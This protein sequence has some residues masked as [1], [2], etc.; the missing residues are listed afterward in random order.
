M[1]VEKI[2]EAGDYR[3]R[4][5]MFRANSVEGRRERSPSVDV[6]VIGENLTT[7]PAERLWEKKYENL[8]G[9]CVRNWFLTDEFWPLAH[10]GQDNAAF[11]VASSVEAVDLK[12]GQPL[13]QLRTGDT[14]V[15]AIRT[16]PAHQH[17]LVLRKALTYGS[18]A[19][20][21]SPEGNV[22]WVA[23]QIL[24]SLSGQDHFRSADP[25][26]QLLGSNTL[27]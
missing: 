8:P 14:W 6:T 23:R 12:T 15:E 7:D 27:T 9:I 13:C 20:C 1:L 26:A 18:N 3:V 22:L 24:R 5:Q 19:F 2:I 25:K 10:P 17:C 11:A 21:I 4:Y 16:S